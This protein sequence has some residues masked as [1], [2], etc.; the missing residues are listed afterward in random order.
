MTKPLARY[1]NDVDLDAE[2]RLIEY[3]EDPML[4]YIKEK[5][6]KEGKRKPEAPS[7]QGSYMPN[8]FSIKPGQRWDGVDRSNGYEKKW[9]EARNAKTAVQEEAYKWSTSDM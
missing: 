6:I 1:A 3:A 9:F 5:Q 8:R 2:R 7:Y 4:G